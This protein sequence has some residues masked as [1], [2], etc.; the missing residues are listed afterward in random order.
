MSISRLLLV[1]DEANN[2]NA[3][4]RLFEDYDLEFTDAEH[5]EEALERLAQQRFDLM[6]L[7]IKMPVMDG[8][9]FLTRYSD[10]DLKPK[11]PVCVMTAFSDSTTRRKA[12]YLGATDFINKPID[13]VELET[14]VASLLRI[15]SYQQDLLAFNHN[16]EQMV[17]ARTRQ[18]KD[19][20]LK[21]QESE[22]QRTRAYREM[23]SRI[24]RLTGFN[25]SEQQLSPHQLA[26]CTAA[27]AWLWGLPKE[28]TENLTLS[29]QL[30][31]IGLLAPPE[32][33]R[34]M[35]PEALTR[36]ELRVLTSYTQ[37]GSGLFQDSEIPLLQQAYRICLNCE[38]HFDGSGM[39]SGLSGETI[40]IE[41]RLLTTARFILNCIRHQP[42]P[43]MDYLRS[44]LQEHAGTL[45]DPNIVEMLMQSDDTLDNL[46][47][48]L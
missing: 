32:K 27:L 14:R 33:L 31:N 39:P 35:P 6:L 20:H 43:S 21:L 42:E 10:L 18:L 13:P 12:I 16:L 48:D 7:D 8:F 4:R 11:P 30:Y 1:D 28:D 40:P 36:D 29:A 34:E 2:R 23:I 5:G 37:I 47:N 25:H 38:E 26:L 19:A 41:A 3:I 9:E 44:S 15:S 46:I 24:T 22:K 45:L 17:E